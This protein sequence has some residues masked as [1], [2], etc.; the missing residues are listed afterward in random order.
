VLKSELISDILALALS[1]GG[2]YA[3]VFVE[4]KRPLTIQLENGSVEKISSGSI[5]GVGIRLIFDE[6][7]TAYA[8]SNDLSPKALKD[9]ARTLASAS[10]GRAQSDIHTI[11]L[12]TISPAVV[13]PCRV[14]P[15]DVAM[16]KKL[17]LLKEADT[18][19]HSI[20]PAIRQVRIIYRDWV[21]EVQIASSEGMLAQETR[22]HTVG[23]VQAV[24]ERDGVVQT[25]SEPVGGALGFELFDD[26][27]L[28]IAAREAAGLSI[29]LLGA[30]R[31]PGG[32]MPVVISSEAGGTMIHEAIGHGLEGDLA[33]QGLSRFSGR[34]GEQVATSLVTVVDDATLAGKRG[35]YGFDDE[36]VP[37][38]RTVLVHDGILKAF[39]NDRLSSMRTGLPLTGNGRRESYLH[40]PIPRMSNTF[41]EPGSHDPAEIL[42][43]TN[44]GFFVKK[45]G[46]GQVNTVNGDFVFDVL[47]GYLIKDGS[48]GELVRGATLT[49]NGPEVLL[50]IDM[51]GS[52][53]GFSIGTCG[54]DSQGVP[55]SDAMPTLR[56][57]DIVVGGEVK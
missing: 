55:V 33:G 43:S 32:R 9:A 41:I 1:R 44:E 13:L 49:G 19:A 56:I 35:S 46:G 39:M 45:M 54:K 15:E 50:A 8:V 21:Q 14:L 51:V 24:A 28:N 12:R 6:D 34:L 22:V 16:D 38:E 25:G 10:G 4:R 7:K 57:P 27:A 31:A 40:R 48:L 18:V 29:K 17:A 3:E 20:D 37:S 42:S 2:R 11:D 5:V 26:D 53:L 47:E 30:N 23:I 52:D 36:G